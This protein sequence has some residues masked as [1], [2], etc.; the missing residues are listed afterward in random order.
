MLSPKDSLI[1]IEFKAKTWILPVD[2]IQRWVGSFNYNIMARSQR[3]QP[4]EKLSQKDKL[5]QKKEGE[6]M[7]Q[8]LKTVSQPV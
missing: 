3:N 8:Q 6:K 1:K 5:K 2:F 4:K 7:R